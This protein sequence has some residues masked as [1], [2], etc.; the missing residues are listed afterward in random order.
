MGRRPIVCRAGVRYK[1]GQLNCPRGVINGDPEMRKS[2][3]ATIRETNG[4]PQIQEVAPAQYVISTWQITMTQRCHGKQEDTKTFPPGVYLI[5]VPEDC[6]IS[7]P[8][9]VLF[10]HKERIGRVSVKSL[11]VTGLIPLNLTEQIPMIRAKSLL[12]AVTPWD[13]LPP[14]ARIALQPFTDEGFEWTDPQSH[15]TWSVPLFLI[16]VLVVGAALIYK[17][18]ERVLACVRGSQTD[19]RETY[20][21][22]TGARVTTPRPHP[23]VHFRRQPERIEIQD[24]E[25]GQPIFAGVHPPTLEVISEVISDDEPMDI[26]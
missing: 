11:Q 26:D 22:F 15:V 25:S 12:K 17:F 10:S 1:P 13:P 21:G 19:Q 7:T 24:E 6:T 2:C 9:W 23:V 18:R 16:S 4:E 8:K 14:V 5:I 3:I 20:I